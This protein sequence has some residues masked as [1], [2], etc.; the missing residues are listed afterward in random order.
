M[1]CEMQLV[2]SHKEIKPEKAKAKS[3]GGEVRKQKETAVKAEAQRK[4]QK[5][6]EKPVKAAAGIMP[7]WSTAYI[8]AC[9][10]R[11]QAGA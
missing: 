4:R 9:T 10:L 7:L 1:I 5:K 3:E 11:S 8:A 6:E 2:T